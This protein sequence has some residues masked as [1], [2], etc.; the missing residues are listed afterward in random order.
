MSYSEP[1]PAERLGL[2]KLAELNRRP[3]AVTT[4]QSAPNGV[5]R[6]GAPPAISP[7]DR[8]RLYLGV[9]A[10]ALVV[11]GALGFYLWSTSGRVELR[12]QGFEI[13][14]ADEMLAAAE[15]RF[16]ETAAADGV[17]LP[18]GAG[19]FFAP[20]NG[21]PI[22]V[23]GPAWLGV[24]QPDRPWL[25]VGSSYTIND[26]RAIGEIG[27]IR[28]ATAADVRTLDRPDGVRPVDPGTPNYPTTGPRLRDGRLLVDVESLLIG[29]EAAFVERVETS[30]DPLITAHDDA[31]CF[32]LQGPDPLDNQP[33][34]PRTDDAVWCGPARTVGS[35]GSRVWIPVSISYDQ[36]PHYGSARFLEAA[37]R[38]ID[39]RAIPEGAELIRPDRVNPADPGGVDR[40]PVPVD[41]ATVVDYQ[42]DVST[43]EPAAAGSRVE[44][45]ALITGR[46]RIDFSSLLRVDAIGTGARSFTAPQGHDLV[47]AVAE[48][49]RSI[50]PRGMLTV[51]GVERPLPRWISSDEGATLVMTVPDAAR[52]V[53]ITVENNGRP[54]T[55]SLLDGSLGDD[56]LLALYRPTAELS[57]PFSVRVEMPVGEA[58]L[59]S[60][61]VESATWFAWDRDN[62]W[63]PA[64]FGEVQFN[65]SEWDVDRPFGGVR[66]DDV[67]ATFTLTPDAEPADGEPANEPAAP[68]SIDDVR[69]DP[70]RSPSAAGPRFRVDETLAAATLNMTVTV[71]YTSDDQQTTTTVD[72]TF[73]VSLP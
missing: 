10:A 62:I 46:Y 36:G 30:T 54:Q 57:Q 73:E 25:T 45:G 27:D 49:G 29:A 50:N 22:V 42:A 38:S 51:D 23:C 70:T 34:L 43:T 3:E 20:E 40:P 18:S 61:V 58:V 68:T 5:D 44:S 37:V 52:S 26:D 1:V 19:C 71:T 17:E 35:A 9:T 11:A 66:I 7:P 55:V 53:T 56:V 2:G 14:N 24:S 59:V 4:P 21:N 48:P 12:Y 41:F 39:P 65:F 8:G 63:L 60:G 64:G 13:A 28:G 69:D 6:H 67:V 33:A 15:A 16:T 32:L 47:V 31:S 72:E